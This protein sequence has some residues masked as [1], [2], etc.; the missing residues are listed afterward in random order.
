MFNFNGKLSDTACILS[1]SNYVKGSSGMIPVCYYSTN[2]LWVIV[3]GYQL[4]F[5]GAFIDLNNVICLATGVRAYIQ[6]M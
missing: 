6:I 5:D 2:N 4:I 3:I 1:I